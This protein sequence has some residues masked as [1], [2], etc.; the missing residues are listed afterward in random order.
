MT[1]KPEH[2]G[3][4]S[5]HQAGVQQHLHDHGRAADQVE[6]FHHVAASRLQVGQHRRGGGDGVEVV[7]ARI[8]LGFVGDG[9]EV[10]H[11]VGRAAE[12]HDH[13]DGIEERLAGHDVARPD[14]AAQQLD[15]RQAGVAQVVALAAVDGGDR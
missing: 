9:D 6:V 7:D 14:A 2:R 13:A 15:N 8:D 1:A 5:L 12:G 11:G 3:Y 4:V 10:Q